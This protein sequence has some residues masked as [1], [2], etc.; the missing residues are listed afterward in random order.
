MLSVKA[1]KQGQDTKYYFEKDNNYYFK[2][3]QA[4]LISAF[5]WDGKGAALLGLK[6]QVLPEDFKRIMEG[7]LPDGQQLG[8]KKGEAMLHRPGFDLTFSAPKSVSILA[9]AGGDDRLIV[10]HQQAVSAA[11]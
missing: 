9:L 6:G 10:L 1:I 4:H 11:L 5:E 3:D 2:D 7:I 8:L